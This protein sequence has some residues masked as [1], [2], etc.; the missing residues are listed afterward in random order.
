MEKNRM[1]IE[2]LILKFNLVNINV[3]KFLMF[4]SIIIPVLYPKANRNKQGR[5]SRFEIF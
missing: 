1:I 5:L 4:V 3:G 2:S